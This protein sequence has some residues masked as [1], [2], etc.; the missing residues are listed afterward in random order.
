MQMHSAKQLWTIKTFGSMYMC[1]TPAELDH[2]GYDVTHSNMNN[3]TLHGGVAGCGKTYSIEEGFGIYCNRLASMGIEGLN[4]ILMGQSRKMVE[5]NQCSVLSNL[6]GS[7]FYFDG[8]KLDGKVK[9]AKL[10]GQNL[11]FV[12]LSD[13]KSEERI[14]GMSD[15]TGIIHDEASIS[16]EDQLSKVFA[17]L[18]GEVKPEI[19][20]M[21]KKEGLLLHWYIGSTNPDGPQHFLLRKYV[22]KGLM[23][24]V[25]WYMSDGIEAYSG[26]EKYYKDLMVDY[27]NCPSLMQRFLYGKWCGSDHLCFPNFRPEKNIGDWEDAW[28]PKVK[29][30][31]IGI[32]AGNNHPC[33]FIVANRTYDGQYVISEEHKFQHTA[34]SDIS[35][36]LSEIYRRLVEMEANVAHIFVDPAALW[37]REELMKAGFNPEGA[38]NSRNEGIG[39]IRT[40]LS[41]G[42]L[43]LDRSCVE[44]KNEFLT[45]SFKDDNSEDV[46]KLDDDFVDALRY[47]VYSDSIIEEGGN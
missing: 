36:K 20:E 32:D 3:K 7:N 47:A 28:Y 24:Y 10:F 46:I 21:F 30:T 34:P 22:N 12:G 25:P 23:K 38:R 6:Y 14:R 27:E 1:N 44:T 2:C 35:K 29:R 15:I 26:A 42:D 41:R 5:T 43:V 39:Y 11:H 45:Y 40:L 37:L 31:V 16:T 17:R 9:D 18:R 8:G 33:A 19:K 13:S 4:F